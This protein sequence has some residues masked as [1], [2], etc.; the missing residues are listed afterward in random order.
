MI[1]KNILV[2]N[3]NQYF[4]QI[5]RHW[6]NQT[7]FHRLRIDKQHIPSFPIWMQHWFWLQQ[8][9]G[10]PLRRNNRM[11]WTNASISHPNRLHPW[12]YSSPTSYSSPLGARKF[13]SN[14]ILLLKQFRFSSN[15]RIDKQTFDHVFH[16]CYHGSRCRR[17]P[18]P[19]KMHS[20]RCNEKLIPYSKPL[21]YTNLQ[22]PYKHCFTLSCC[23]Y[24]NPNIL[25]CC[26]I[27][28]NTR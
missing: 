12:S 22:C 28:E 15:C 3:G 14:R 13:N 16:Q 6:F 23:H 10:R 9:L 25:R 1:S 2:C 18:M 20:T 19:L 4:F 26:F 7:P 8:L 11:G 24:I 21:R 17:L 5:H 27:V